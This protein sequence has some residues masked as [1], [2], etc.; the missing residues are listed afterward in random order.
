M[1]VVCCFLYMMFYL[2]F[3]T[4][5]VYS[6]KF[7][8]C[9]TFHEFFYVKTVWY[10]FAA[11]ALHG[12]IFLYSLQNWFNKLCLSEVKWKSVISLLLYSCS[13]RRLH[14]CYGGHCIRLHSWCCSS[15][16]YRH[17][18]VLQVESLPLSPILTYTLYVQ[19]FQILDHMYP[20]ILLI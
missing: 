20:R 17:L 5:S 19:D 9:A 11:L 18:C 7:N 6:T 15:H 13:T 12:S 3:Y 2:L 14:W 10:M 1:V 16:S 8:S 4:F